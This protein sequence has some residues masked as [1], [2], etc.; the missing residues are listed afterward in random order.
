MYCRD[1]PVIKVVSFRLM[2]KPLRRK[3]PW[4]DWWVKWPM[5]N[6]YVSCR[7][8][9]TCMHYTSFS[10]SLGEW[11][12]MYL[13]HVVNLFTMFSHSALVLFISSNVRMCNRMTSSL[14]TWRY[15]INWPTRPCC[16]CLEEETS[17][18]AIITRAVLIQNLSSNSRRHPMMITRINIFTTK[19]IVFCDSS[20]LARWQIL[21]FNS[22]LVVNA[23]AL[24]LVPSSWRI[25]PSCCW[26][27]PRLVRVCFYSSSS[28]N[29]HA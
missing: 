17:K 20:G 27:N 10:L 1:D 4:N 19:L 14:V 23:S 5:S 7:V 9:I 2:A 15:A 18:T 24:I 8:Y 26:M 11:K 13:F 16:A 29:I 3:V 25:Q 21:L 22:C 28:K 12:Q 6:K